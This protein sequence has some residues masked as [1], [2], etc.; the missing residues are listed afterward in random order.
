MAWQKIMRMP[1]DWHTEP[2]SRRRHNQ[3]GANTVGMNK[4]RSFPNDC[5]TCHANHAREGSE[6]PNQT[7]RAPSKARR[8]R[9]H[10]GN[11]DTHVIYHVD[12]LPVRWTQHYGI[13]ATIKAG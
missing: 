3:T 5:R 2:H 13:D 8:Q 7:I 9:V 6:I 12:Q 11:F 1:D 4:I 10:A